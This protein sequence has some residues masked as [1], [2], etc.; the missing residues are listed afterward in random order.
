MHAHACMQVEDDSNFEIVLQFLASFAG[1]LPQPMDVK[2][3]LSTKHV[4]CQT[5]HMKRSKC[6]CVCHTHWR[7]LKATGVCHPVQAALSWCSQHFKL[8]PWADPARHEARC[9]A[10]E[11]RVLRGRLGQRPRAPW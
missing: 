11:I 2:A 5:P 9:M 4:H 3:G 7:Y 6:V 1:Q 8:N 10:R